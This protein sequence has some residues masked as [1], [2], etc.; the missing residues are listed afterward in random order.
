ME[1]VLGHPPSERQEVGR[2]RLVHDLDHGL[3]PVDAGSRREADDSAFYSP[4]AEGHEH[5]LTLN[6]QR[7]Q[8]VGNLV[9]ECFVYGDWNSDFNDRA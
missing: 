9:M 8:L 3:E 4:A 1:I 6:D 5:A 7:T 2:K